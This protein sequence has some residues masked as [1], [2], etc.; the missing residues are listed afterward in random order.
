MSNHSGSY[1][2]NDV[3]YKLDELGVFKVLGEDKTLEFVQWL[4]EYTEEEYDTNP[5][6]ILDGIGAKLKIC[7]S[8]LERKEDVNEYGLCKECRED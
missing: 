2:L 3:L 8:C 7:Y 5:G 1:M 6:E 4:C